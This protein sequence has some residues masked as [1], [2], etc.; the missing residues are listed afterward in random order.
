LKEI[1][2]PVLSLTSWAS[3][4][5]IAHR[6]MATSSIPLLNSISTN[7]SIG[8]GVHSFLVSSL[9]LLLVFRTNSAYQRFVVRSF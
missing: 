7:M 3:I 5:A 6:F 2:N 1:C 8:L 4:F 9:G